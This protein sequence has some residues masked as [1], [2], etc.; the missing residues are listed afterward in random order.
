MQQW[1][2]LSD[3][4]ME[5]ALYEI[6]SMRRFAGFSLSSGSIPDQTTIPNVR[7]LLG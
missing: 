6:A 5:E 7:D 2:G 3:P 4:A 1:D